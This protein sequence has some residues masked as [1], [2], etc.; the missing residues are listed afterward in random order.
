[1]MS[2]FTDDFCFKDHAT[3]S[4]F[5]YLISRLMTASFLKDVKYLKN[6]NDFIALNGGD[7]EYSSKY[8]KIIASSKTFT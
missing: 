3:G 8:F 4:S 2:S 5:K 1:M 6:L 7:V